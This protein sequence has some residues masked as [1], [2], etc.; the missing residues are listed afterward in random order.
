LPT[1]RSIRTDRQPAAVPE[2][3]EEGGPEGSPGDWRWLE[4]RY[5]TEPEEVDPDEVGPDIPEA[6][7]APDMTEVD[8]DP[9]LQN[10]FWALVAV[11]N[12]ALLAVSLGVMFVGFRGNWELGGQLTV[13]GLLLFG[14][15]YYRYRKTKAALADGDRAGNGNDGAESG[16]G[17]RSADA[18]DRN[19]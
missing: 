10:R 12:L 17:H 15:G 16:G 1:E 7:K 6:P 3:D 14:F 8:V 5:S 9:G 11:F 18:D 19:G 4:Q 2:D 13:G